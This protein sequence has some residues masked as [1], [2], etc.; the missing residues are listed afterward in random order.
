MVLEKSLTKHPHN[1]GFCHETTQCEMFT[2]YLQWAYTCEV[3]SSERLPAVPV[4]ILYLHTPRERELEL[5][6]CRTIHLGTVWMTRNQN[7]GINARLIFML[8]ICRFC[9]SFYLLFFSLSYNTYGSWCS[10]EINSKKNKILHNK[11]I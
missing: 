7:T 9:G 8:Y 10:R 4:C 3:N 1:A 6:T 5:Y 2:Y 11:Q